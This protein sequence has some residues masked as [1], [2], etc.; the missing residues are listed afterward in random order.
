MFLGTAHYAS[1]EQIEGKELD[2]RSDVYSLG[3]VLYECLTGTIPRTRRT[4]RWR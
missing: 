1:P 3:C 4:P 2:A